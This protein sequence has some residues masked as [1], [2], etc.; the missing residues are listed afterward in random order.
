MSD[1][2]TVLPELILA[3]GA[4][5]LLMIGVFSGDKSYGLLKWLASGLFAVAFLV[6]IGSGAEQKLAF[7]GM[8]VTD[9]FALFMK[10]VVL[11]GA[12][13]ALG[14][15]GQ[16]MRERG[17]ARFEYP[18]LVVLAVLGMMMMVSAN[19]MLALY[20]GLE[21]QSLALYVLAAFNRD[22]LRSTEAGLKYFVLGA[23]SSGMMLY[24]ISL[25]YGFT[26]STSFA[27]IAAYGIGSGTNGLGLLFGLV[28]LISGFAFKVSAVPFHMWA[29]DVYEGAPTPITVFFGTA[30]KVAAMALFVRALIVS[31]PDLTQQ[32]QQVVVFLSV[33]SMILGAFAGLMQ[34]NIKRLMAY[35]SIAHM[36]FALAG[37]ATGTVDG[38]QGVLVY[39][40]IYM[41]MT[42]GTFAVI[43]G[44]RRKDGLT[45][46]ISDLAGLAK[47]RPALAAIMATLMFSLAGIPLLAGFFAKL[48]V[49]M[50]VVE[51]GMYWL[52]VVG[53]V[54]STVAAVYYLRIVKLMYFDEPNENIEPLKDRGIAYVGFVTAALNSPLHL[55]L[56]WPLTLAAGLAAQSLF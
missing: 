10:S 47:T 45:E 7:G 46:D 3:V 1:V 44:M 5:G 21:L 33:A 56:I 29:P 15:S 12:V 20:I 43:L 40:A 14:L 11:T 37:L 22:K 32:W 13:F 18:V 41:L 8:F 53:F 34:T 24:G 16:F 25:I 48:Y 52:A 35:S 51:A 36:G 30:P 54:T 42:A 31:F 6:M 2:L 17:I 39:M 55:L 27:E 26:G 50:A 4:M 9:A 49:F 19:D 38:V 23:L 28:F